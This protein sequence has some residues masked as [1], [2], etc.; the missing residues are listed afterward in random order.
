MSSWPWNHDRRVRIRS[1]RRLDRQPINRKLHYHSWQPRYHTI[2][3]V[4]IQSFSLIIYISFVS[5]IIT[6][7]KG[8]TIGK[9]KEIS[10]VWNT[11]RQIVDGQCL[12]TQS[13]QAIPYRRTKKI[14]VTSWTTIGRS[15]RTSSS[16]SLYYHRK[17]N[18]VH[19][20]LDRSKP[21]CPHSMAMRSKDRAS[22][23]LFTTRTRRFLVGPVFVT[24]TFWRTTAN[25]ADPSPADRLLKHTHTDPSI[26][27]YTCPRVFSA[28][29]LEINSP[30]L[31]LPDAMDGSRFPTPHLGLLERCR[32]AVMETGRFYGPDEA[33]SDLLALFTRIA[34]KKKRMD[35]GES[36]GPCRFLCWI[37]RHPVHD[38][39]PLPTFPS[40][41]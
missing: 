6:K 9:E 18:N 3:I 21:L 30:S 4:S 36:E 13:A 39:P 12:I 17:S 14:W 5:T 1:Y 23:Y 10:T 40:N 27:I 29:F 33:K 38:I 22:D 32:N 31:S 19:N 34:I 16:E 41:E 7:R 25:R 28:S 8:D 26:R 20:G 15:I 37:S 11:H 24:Q 35:V 2:H